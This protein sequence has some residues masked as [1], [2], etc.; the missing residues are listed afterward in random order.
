[1]IRRAS[2][3]AAGLAAL[4]LAHPSPALAA[5]NL[6]IVDTSFDHH[7]NPGEPVPMNVTVRNNESTPQFAEVD[8]SVTNL[9]T[10]AELTLV[11]VFGRTIAPTSQIVLSTTYAT[12]SS[13]PPTRSGASNDIPPGIYTVAFTLVD[14]NGDRCDQV[15]ATF[16]LHVG[17]ETESLRVFPEVLNLGTLPP[18]RYLC[19]T[20]FEVRW[21]FFQFNRLRQDQPFS[22]RIYTDNAARYHGIPHALRAVSPAGL[23][24]MDGRYVIPVKCWMLNFGPDIQESGWDAA[25]A[26]PPPV[27]EDD[28]WL[29]P[30]L[31]EGGRSLGSAT[32][33]RIP[34]LVD[35]TPDPVTW[36]RL[37]GQDQ[38]DN[39]F[40]SDP[41]LT[42]DFTLRSPFTVYLATETG[43]NSVEGTYSANLV[44]ELWNP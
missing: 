27:D 39:R 43:A 26:G 9:E 1:M 31:L 17:T 36:R 35:M 2:L 20:P 19:P 7:F 3:L 5:F 25:L 13:P 32:W 18:G 8:V 10:G 38:Y 15:R 11:P 24:S 29:G 14:G 22:I 23:V 6:R 30:P 33:V 44:V 12:S 41:N 40:I 37:I 4:W 16:P 28:Y 34:D 42:G 21:S